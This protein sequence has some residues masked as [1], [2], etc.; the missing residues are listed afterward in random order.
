MN[1][2]QSIIDVNAD[3]KFQEEY[4]EKLKHK[5]KLNQEIL[6]FENNQQPIYVNINHPWNS[7]KVK[8]KMPEIGKLLIED[9]TDKA[10]FPKVFQNDVEELVKETI[11][12]ELVK[13]TIVEEL[14]KE[15]IVEEFVKETIVEEFVKETIVEELVKETIDEE[16]ID[17]N[18]NENHTYVDYRT[19][20]RHCKSKKEEKFITNVTCKTCTNNNICGFGDSCTRSNCSRKHL[21]SIYI[22]PVCQNEGCNGDVQKMYNNDYYHKYCWDCHNSY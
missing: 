12:E 6:E 22:K 2:Q 13:E 8:H 17:E 21:D 9:I 11:V 16:I 7:N 14:V 19:H 20:C 1:I 4:L 18:I 3:I 5:Q 10:L 15:T